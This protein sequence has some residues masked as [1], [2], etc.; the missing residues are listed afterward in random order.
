MRA[1][2][3]TG[4]RESFELRYTPWPRTESDLLRV[5][6][7]DVSAFEDE[8]PMIDEYVQ[9]VI[10]I[11][12]KREI[13][14]F[15]ARAGVHATISPRDDDERDFPAKPGNSSGACET[16]GPNEYRRSVWYDRLFDFS[17]V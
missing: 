7:S 14:R 16:E 12:D 5:R 17:G 15:R 4:E 3:R 9:L 1:S 2:E 8:Q 10:P 6:P 11:H 13:L